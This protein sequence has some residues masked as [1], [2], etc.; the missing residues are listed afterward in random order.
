LLRR[1][2]ATLDTGL[3]LIHVADVA[4]GHL[5]AA[6][7]GRVSEKYILGCQNLSLTEIFRML[8]SVTGIR[9]PRVRV[10]HALIYVVARHQ[11]GPD[12]TERADAARLGSRQC[13]TI[14]AARAAHGRHRAITRPG[15]FRLP[16]ETQGYRLAPSAMIGLEHCTGWPPWGTGTRGR[17]WGSCPSARLDGGVRARGSPSRERAGP[18]PSSTRAWTPSRRGCLRSASRLATRSRSG[19]LR[20]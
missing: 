2:F 9:A 16:S 3:N 14:V 4:R 20:S 19:W 1:M 6:Q 7:R 13:L 11:V 5:L 8:E 17:R 12:A 15:R 10:P 18:L